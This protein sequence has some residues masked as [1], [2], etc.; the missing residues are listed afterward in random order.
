MR[1]LEDKEKVRKLQ[2]GHGH[3]DNEISKV[4]FFF[5][6]IVIYSLGIN[7]S[8]ANLL[9]NLTRPKQGFLLAVRWSTRSSSTN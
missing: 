1:I 6:N 2:Q 7:F 5:D 4:F 8:L 3:W 9:T